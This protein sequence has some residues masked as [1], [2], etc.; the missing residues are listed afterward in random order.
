M[1]TLSLTIGNIVQ[2]KHWRALFYSIQS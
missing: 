2:N 1:K